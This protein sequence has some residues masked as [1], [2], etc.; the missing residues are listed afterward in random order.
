MN[1]QAAVN[2]Q[3]LGAQ[4]A[5]LGTTLATHDTVTSLQ[6]SLA[7]EIVTLRDNIVTLNK[8]LSAVCT[9]P[10]NTLVCGDIAPLHSL[11]ALAQLQTLIGQVRSASQ[12]VRDMI[13]G[14]RV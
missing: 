3:V 4:Y 9:P 5:G 8:A 12:E 11:S 13:S 10:G 14:L 2:Q 6:N 1:H 7:D